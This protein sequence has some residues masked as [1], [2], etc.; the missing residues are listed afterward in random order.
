[1]RETRGSVKIAII[2]DVF[3]GPLLF[4]LGDRKARRQGKKKLSSHNALLLQKKSS[5]HW[6]RAMLST[7]DSFAATKPPKETGKGRLN[8]LAEWPDAKWA[9]KDF[10]D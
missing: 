5:T 7:Q 6:G 4:A 9:R 2:C 3:P 10:E 8:L 1:M